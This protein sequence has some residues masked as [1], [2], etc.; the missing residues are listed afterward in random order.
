M[1]WTGLASSLA[2]EWATP[3][4]S[5]KVVCIEE[6]FSNINSSLVFISIGDLG[7]AYAYELGDGFHQHWVKTNDLDIAY[8]YN[9][10]K[11]L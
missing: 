9:V 2:E 11:K 6:H 8:G 5:V 7:D 1:L 3:G 10:L 4:F